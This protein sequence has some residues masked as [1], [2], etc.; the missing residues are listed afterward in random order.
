MIATGINVT[1]L[2]SSYQ[3]ARK[4]PFSW[5]VHQNLVDPGRNYVRDNDTPLLH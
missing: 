1:I 3:N 2:A 4:L 5:Y